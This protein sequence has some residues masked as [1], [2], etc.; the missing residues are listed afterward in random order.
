[1]AVLWSIKDTAMSDKLLAILDYRASILL[2]IL[3]QLSLNPDTEIGAD[4]F[5]YVPATYNDLTVVTFLVNE[6]L[7]FEKILIINRQI[8]YKS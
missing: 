1:M 5:D 4:N 2:Q 3:K 7:G 6:F 8:I